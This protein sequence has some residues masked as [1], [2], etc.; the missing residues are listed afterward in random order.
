MEETITFV[1]FD[2]KQVL[3]G[4]DRLDSVGGGASP[5][6]TMMAFYLGAV[7]NLIALLFLLDGDGKS[8]GGSVYPA[9]AKVGLSHHLDGV[10]SVLGA[11]IGNA[12]F[13]EAIRTF[14]NKVMVHSKHRSSDL[15]RPY[16]LVDMLDIEIQDRWQELLHRLRSQVWDLSVTLIR[17]SGRSP[18]DFGFQ[19]L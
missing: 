11:E 19:S 4:F 16:D 9:L 17:E 8:M 3:Y 15:E 2:L 5:G 14:R 10:R 6:S 18:E 1:V 13:G 7:Y 12:T